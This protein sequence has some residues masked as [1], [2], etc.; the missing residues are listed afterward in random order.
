MLRAFPSTLDCFSLVIQKKEPKSD[1]LRV[2]NV[3]VGF[4]RKGSWVAEGQDCPSSFAQLHSIIQ[5]FSEP[6]FIFFKCFTDFWN[7][8]YDCGFYFSP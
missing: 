3:E 8:G 2:M 4:V 5:T 6:L 1:E 7:I